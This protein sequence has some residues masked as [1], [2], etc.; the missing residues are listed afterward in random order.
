MYAW[1]VAGWPPQQDVGVPLRTESLA[2]SAGCRAAS[3][4]V[5]L[6]TAGLSGGPASPIGD[7]YDCVVPRALV[8]RI[9]SVF[10]TPTSVR[11]QRTRTFHQLVAR[12]PVREAYLAIRTL[13]GEQIVLASAH[14]SGRARLF[15]GKTCGPGG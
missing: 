8:V 1:I 15:V 5:P 10:R 3:G 13:S 11:R 2:F 14:E 6:S 4:R 12:G 7:E 9:K